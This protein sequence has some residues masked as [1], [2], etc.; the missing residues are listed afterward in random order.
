M[1][2]HEQTVVEL[3][4]KCLS[5]VP[6][7]VLGSGASLQY[8][9]G[10]MKELGEWLERNVVPSDGSE[11]AVWVNFVT[12]IR[13]NCDLEGALQRVTLPA[14]LELR[15]IEETRKL[16]LR[17]D[18][19]VFANMVSGGL[20][21]ALTEL[22]R[23]LLRTTHSSV[24]VVTTNYDRLAE[25]ASDQAGAFHHTGFSHGYWR[26]LSEFPT[27]SQQWVEILKV[28]GSLDWFLD[29]NQSPVA[30]P[31]AL[32]MPPS[33]VPVMVTPGIGKYEK[34]HD[35]PFRTIITR[36]DAAFATARAILSIGYGFR[37]RHLQPKMQKRIANDRIPTVFL[38]R[39]ISPELRRFLKA[40]VNPHYLALEESGDK[41]RAYFAKAPDGVEI[42][43]SI[44]ELATFLKATIGNS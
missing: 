10:G 30:L 41:T 12:D 22:L 34:T 5:E 29:S 35:D 40:C 14:S 21:L 39:I 9:V 13:K 28:H 25:Y 16:V 44:W 20:R 38:A 36:A 4:Q 15:V 17:D 43:G 2:S 33:F 27:K 1:A 3:A 42:P 26:T 8:G 18:Q 7:V 23:H 11:K 31:D 32:P 24:V 19:K 37:D 6:V